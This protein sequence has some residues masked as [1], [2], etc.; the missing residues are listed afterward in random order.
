[1]TG[2]KRAATLIDCHLD[3]DPIRLI[4]EDTPG[5]FRWVDV[6]LVIVMSAVVFGLKKRYVHRRI[7][8]LS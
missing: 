1:M 2:K 8:A 6:L 7:H 5:L 3:P 4:M